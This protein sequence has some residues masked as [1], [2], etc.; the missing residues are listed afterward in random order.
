MIQMPATDHICSGTFISEPEARFWKHILLQL[1]NR[2]RHVALDSRPGLPF[3]PEAYL[4]KSPP[5]RTLCRICY[6]HSFVF[7]GIIN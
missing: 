6:Q 2:C 4:R 1:F 5:E 7:K 3:N